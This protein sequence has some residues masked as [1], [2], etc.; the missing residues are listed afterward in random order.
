MLLGV[1]ENPEFSM[2]ETTGRFQASVETSK[3]T[4]TLR[5]PGTTS[6]EQPKELLTRSRGPGHV[7]GIFGPLRITV[8]SCGCKRYKTDMRGGIVVATGAQGAVVRIL[9]CAILNG[10]SV[11]IQLADT[12]RWSCENSAT[13]SPRHLRTTSRSRVGF[14]TLRPTQ[15]N[16]RPLPGPTGTVHVDVIN[17]SSDQDCQPVVRFCSATAHV[18]V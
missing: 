9:V 17:P 15:T 5:R 1:S 16:R 7:R 2:C 13:P 3:R 11:S 12:V 6:S 14:T 8:W 4:Q 10:L 18:P